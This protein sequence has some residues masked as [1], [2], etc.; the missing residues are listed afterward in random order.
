MKRHVW[1]PLSEFPRVRQSANLAI[2]ALAVMPAQMRE[3][4]MGRSARIPITN[5]YMGGDYTGRI[6]VGPR[7]RAL[8]VILD[9]G[10]SALAVDARK[11]KP[12]PRRGDKTTRVAQVEAYGDG[13]HWTGAVIRTEVAIGTGR[14]T[15]T[16]ADAKLSVAYRRSVDCFGKADGILGLAYKQLDDA[17]RM[18]HD[19]WHHQ[20]PTR[21]LQAK[22]KKTYLAPYLTQLAGEGVISDKFAFLTRRSFTHVGRGRNDS[23]NKGWMIVGGGEE[24][25]DLYKG[26]FESVRVFSKRFYYTKLKAIIVGRAAPIRMESGKKRTYNSLIDSG[27][28]SLSFGPGLLRAIFS[29]LSPLQLALLKRAMAGYVVK[30]AELDLPSWPT[31]TFVM[32]GSTRDVHLQVRPS[33]YWQ[34]NTDRVGWAAVAITRGDGKAILGLPLMNGYFTVFDGEADNGRGVVKFARR[35]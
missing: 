31:I 34:V 12:D 16:L 25:T 6:F 15:I 14:S 22:R 27:T 7:R 18:P 2:F 1:P 28:N 33:N 24:C 23:L 10:S 11:Y 9:T 26:R 3:S 35:R 4:S 21:V 17:Y 8:N 30:V 13:S 5:A 29:K 19:T 20:Y 32:Q